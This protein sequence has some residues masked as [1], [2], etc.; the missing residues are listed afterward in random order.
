MMDGMW[1]HSTE[2]HLNTEQLTTIEK[3][4][5]K[6]LEHIELGELLVTFPSG[7]ERRFTGEIMEPSGVVVGEMHIK[8]WSAITRAMKSGAIGLAEGYMAGEWTSP[9]LTSLLRVLA[10]NMDVLEAKLKR[11]PLQKTRERV[12]HWLNRN[13]KSGSRKNISY[14][15]DLGN[16]FY[17]LWLDETMT[18]SAG[19]YDQ[20]S[21]SLE[22]AQQ[23]KYQSLAEAIGIKS[24]D[25]ILEI[26]CGWGGFAEYAISNFD[27][28]V[29]GVTL[30][31]EQL[32]YANERLKNKGLDQRADLC[33]CD[34]RDLSGTFDHIVS[35]EMLEAVGEEYWSTYFDQLKCLLKPKGCVGIQVIT[36]EDS[37]FEA[38][39]RNVDFIQ[40][41]IFPGGM[42][43]SDS[44]MKNLIDQRGFTLN[45]QQDFGLG[46]AE[47]LK[48]WHQ[49]Y[50]AQNSAVRALGYDDRFDR[51]WRFYLSYCEAGFRQKTIDVSQYVFG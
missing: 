12:G 17:S 49:N 33:L 7:A 41:Y 10:V 44:I 11:A 15:Y 2:R 40:K 46:Y 26:G 30:S 27:C 8:K 9:D 29:T 38:Y 21:T 13:N 37:R 16:D 1:P 23:A 18:Y 45:S 24:G 47:T 4:F 51:M 48:Q 50:V 43:P 14:H 32:A 39:S 22:N 6:V 35:I 3:L 28:S 5:A 34:Y 31:T 19:L 36:I 25:H 42:L 20:A